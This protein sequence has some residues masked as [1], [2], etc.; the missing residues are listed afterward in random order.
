MDF[1]FSSD[2]GGLGGY[3]VMADIGIDPGSI[4]YEGFG[5]GLGNDALWDSFNGGDY[6]FQ[7]VEGMEGGD[8]YLG[9]LS[10]TSDPS[11]PSTVTTASEPERQNP[12][13]KA[14]G[15]KG[16]ADGT[17]TDFSDPK[18]ISALIKALGVGGNFLNQLSQRGKQANAQ[19]AAQLQRQLAQNPYNSWTPL[20]QMWAN[21]VFNQ[22]FTPSDQRSRQYASEMR[23]PIEAG[24]GYAEGGDVDGP[25]AEETG[26]LGLV[27]GQGMGQAD[28]VPVN[29]SGGEYVW[30]ADVVSALGDGNNA[31]GAAI[32]DQAREEIRKRNRSAPPDKIPPAALP[33]EQYMKKGR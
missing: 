29:L 33:L 27:A 4:D 13:L 2:T 30:D 1:D 21:Q 11:S 20:Q 32:L 24:R 3:D 6:G 25:P 8:Q 14:L 7:P 10:Q 12:I 28:D 15:F 16:T 9:P 23:S 19:T 31:A 26:A 5:S 17:A 18:S 22:G